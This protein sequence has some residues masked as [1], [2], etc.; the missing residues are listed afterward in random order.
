MMQGSVSG[1]G[2]PRSG[3]LRYRIE[4]RDGGWSVVINGCS[5]RAMPRSAAERV[6][7]A[8]QAE[9]NGLRHQEARSWS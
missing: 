3:P 6:A 7:E 5:T 9:A 1:L 4:P 2:K 8:L